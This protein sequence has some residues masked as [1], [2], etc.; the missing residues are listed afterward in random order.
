LVV[1]LGIGD[2]IDAPDGVARAVESDR[3][4]FVMAEMTR[5]RCAEKPYRLDMQQIAMEEI[6]PEAEDQ[7]ADQ[8]CDDDRPDARR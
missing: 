3:R 1:A 6:F 4:Q 7:V 5:A 8:A 2:R